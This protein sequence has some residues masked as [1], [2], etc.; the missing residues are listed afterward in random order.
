MLRKIRNIVGGGIL[1]KNWKTMVCVIIAIIL[2]LALVSYFRKDSKEYFED[3]TK[4]ILRM[5]YVKWCPHCTDAKP[6]FNQCNVANVKFEAVDAE[7]EDNKD[8][9]NE[10]GVSGY[11]T[12]VFYHNGSKIEYDG[13]R[14]KNEIET[15]VTNTLG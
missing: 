8:L 10:A 2:S 1:K 14:S 11:P 3:A 15:W 9:V 5:F 7:E 13:G 4:G 6:I 12:Y